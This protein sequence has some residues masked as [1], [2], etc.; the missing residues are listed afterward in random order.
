LKE[1]PSKETTWKNT[2]EAMKKRSSSS[3]RHDMTTTSAKAKIKKF[4]PFNVTTKIVD[5]ISS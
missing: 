2:I 4:K 1:S 3:K 5:K